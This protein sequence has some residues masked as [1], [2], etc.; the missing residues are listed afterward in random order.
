MQAATLLLAGTIFTL[1]ALAF[2][3]GYA[4]PGVAGG[5]LVGVGTT[6]TVGLAWLLEKAC[7]RPAA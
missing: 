5:V 1:G 2:A 6:S 4:L 3:A 7:R